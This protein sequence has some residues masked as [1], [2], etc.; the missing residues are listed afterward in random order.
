[1]LSTAAC[2]AG[3]N[4]NIPNLVNKN[5]LIQNQPTGRGAGCITPDPL[6]LPMGLLSLGTPLDWP[7]AA[8]YA[9]HVRSEG[10]KQFINAYRRG[11]GH[12]S[13]FWTW[14]DEV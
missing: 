9:D 12:N 10:I 4:N 7:E 1:M 11:Q 6:A 2:S 14:G 8:Q 13:A 3:A 5:S